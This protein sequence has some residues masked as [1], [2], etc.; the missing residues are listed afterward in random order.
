MGPFSLSS[1]GY[2]VFDLSTISSTSL[3]MFF[4]GSSVTPLRRATTWERRSSH[5]TREQRARKARNASQAGRAFG[6]LGGL[7]SD[8]TCNSP[9]AGLAACPLPRCP[10]AP[11]S[12]ASTFPSGASGLARAMTI[13]ASGSSNSG[14]SRG[15]AR[16]ALN[17]QV[18]EMIAEDDERHS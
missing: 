8:V 18:E 17:C 15:M 9:L 11:W 1:Y 4:S 6:R 16:T 10:P 7:G 5:T 2:L 12:R 14:V 13:R 3:S